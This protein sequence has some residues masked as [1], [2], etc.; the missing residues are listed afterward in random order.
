MV[1]FFQNAATVPPVPFLQGKQLPFA[2]S[3]P[4]NGNYQT[5]IRSHAAA[6]FARFNARGLFQDHLT[7][8]WRCAR[9]CG[10]RRICEQHSDR[11]RPHEDCAGPGAVSKPAKRR[12]R[13]MIRWG[14]GYRSVAR[15][16]MPTR[17]RRSAPAGA[18]S[19]TTSGAVDYRTH[20]FMDSF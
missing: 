9:C 15:G 19:N 14:P 10:E 4:N 7:K 17:D 20:V 1:T 2:S 13:R 8:G 18:A 3:V 12:N 6:R 16:V 11:Q 5:Q